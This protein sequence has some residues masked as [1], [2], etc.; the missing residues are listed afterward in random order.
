MTTSI[1]R[2][3][4][5]CTVHDPRDAGRML[6]RLC[7]AILHRAIKR[8]TGTLPEAVLG[9]TREALASRMKQIGMELG[10]IPEEYGGTW[11]YQQSSHNIEA[12]IKQDKSVGEGASDTDEMDANHTLPSIMPIGCH[13]EP[14]VLPT[15]TTA[16]LTLPEATPLVMQTC[17]ELV[18]SDPRR[19]R[20]RS[21]YRMRNAQY[22]RRNYKRQRERNDAIHA[23][24]KI[25]LQENEAL[26]VEQ[27]RLEG[28]LEQA[29][30]IVTGRHH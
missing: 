1:V 30:A 6:V 12:R 2:F 9:D 11:S 21:F 16:S 3:R 22:S 20:D 14:I 5:V 13:A 7:L 24:Y 15:D 26:R 10:C 23:D 19:K 17:M 25:A 18:Q 8:W 4:H 29:K 27:S 28:L